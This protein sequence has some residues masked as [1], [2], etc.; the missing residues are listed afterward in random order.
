M[1]ESH[2]PKN[3]WIGLGLND[4]PSMVHHYLLTYLY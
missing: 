2:D 3:I 4:K 1:S